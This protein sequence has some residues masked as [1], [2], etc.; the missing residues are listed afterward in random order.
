MIEKIMKKYAV[1]R[2]GAI[3]LIKGCVWTAIQ[4]F[5]FM[6]PVALMYRLISDIMGEKNISEDIPLFTFGCI[7]SMILIFLASW[8]QYDTTYLATYK[9]SGVRR[10]ALAE[11][12]RQ[13]PLSFFDNKNL[14]DLSETMMSDCQ[15][16]E[17]GFSHNVPSL[18]GS[19]ISTFI[20]GIGLLAFD[21]R[22]GIAAFWVIPV[23]LL[24]IL[25]SKKVQYGLDMKAI[26]A[27]LTCAEG[28]QEY[29]ET[30]RDLKECNA[31]GQYIKGLDKKIDK[32]AKVSFG[33]KFGMTAYAMSAGLF[34]KFGIVTVSIV[35]VGL[36][37]DGQISK[38]LFIMYLF[39]AARLYDPLQSV[40]QNIVAINALRVNI[41]RMSEILEYPI[42]EGTT[43][44]NNQG[45]DIAFNHVGFSYDDNETVLKDVSFVAKQGEITA[46]VGPSGGGKTTVSRL[47]TRFW[48]IEKGTI[49]L[50]GTDI[51][52]VSPEELMKKYSIVFQNVMLFDDSIMENIRLGKKDATD[53]EVIAAA[54][55]ANCDEFVEK[56]PEGYHTMIGE[57][58]TVLSGG[59]RQR[60]SI[61][62]AFLKDAPI[63]LLDEATASLDVENES[64][65][66]VAISK[67][68]A[69]KTV[70][71]I[72]HRMRTV[73]N[74]D[75]VVVLKDGKVAEMGKPEQLIE[76]KGTFAKMAE[77]QGV[78]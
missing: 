30:I 55:M 16:L 46:L 47:V 1:S 63:I 6:V 59:E 3:D 38:L 13:I 50:G 61:A 18:I 37:I 25:L 49:T 75:Q 21:W 41:E 8:L 19:M 35:G 78:I 53:E 22:M 54:K 24:I 73:V 56:L 9:E 33:S 48:D 44:L 58:G 45:Y 66:Q 51:S 42:Q 23:S 29:V 39:V 68:I 65:I 60:I 7:V 36:L 10:I 62:R 69:N 74:A 17:V 15:A 40:L 52:K 31:T 34:L 27:K 71:I 4:N 77:L 57:N 76:K 28:I 14:T 32:M 12:I 26:H 43:E 2:Q 72:A 70:L 11:R 5:S 64:K 67:L 20:I